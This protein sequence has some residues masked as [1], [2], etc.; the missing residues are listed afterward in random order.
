VGA[1]VPSLNLNLGVGLGN[2][3]LLSVAVQANLAPASVQAEV[4][5]AGVL[6]LG[7]DLGASVRLGPSVGVS[8]NAAVAPGA[9][10]EAAT[11][12]TAPPLPS[13]Q[14][15]PAVG[16]G[17]GASL[18]AAG[19]LAS[20]ELLGTA[21]GVAAM[22]AVGAGSAV[23]RAVA[24]GDPASPGNL[25]NPQLTLSA[26]AQPAPGPVLSA[27]P[28]TGI[29]SPSPASNGL[30]A[31]AG[32]GGVTPSLTVPAAPL[33]VRDGGGEGGGAE[34][35]A[36]TV[37]PAPG[38]PLAPP[39]A[40]VPPARAEAGADEEAEGTTLPGPEAPGPLT[41]LTAD[42]PSGAAAGAGRARAVIEAGAWPDYWRL[43]PWLA[44]LTAAAVGAEVA[45]RRRQAASAAARAGGH[46]AEEA[47]WGLPG[48][49]P[50]EDV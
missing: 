35:P 44:G 8:V 10:L 27:V 48:H 47:W 6:G 5:G 20:K 26:G 17:L 23:L 19:T 4:G 45:R 39:P 11:S 29:L 14:S 3:Q 24:G 22:P 41:D 15:S 18:E 13:Q 7:A 32:V 12:V 34:G 50:A 37:A 46:D 43:T 9:A 28:V 38:V 33:P 1:A 16:P 31:A 42:E 2:Q 36:P 30:S 25:V 49:W 21:A 40:P